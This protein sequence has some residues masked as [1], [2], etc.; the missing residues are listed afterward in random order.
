MKKG[1][2]PNTAESIKQRI[3]QDEDGCWIWQGYKDRDGYGRMRLEGKERFTHRIAYEAWVAALEPNK[4][5]MHTCDKPA[6]CNP[7]HLK[8]GTQGENNRD[9]AAK[10]RKAKGSANGNA[11][12]TEY[13]VSLIRLWFT[14]G[15]SGEELSKIFNISRVQIR[16]ILTLKNW[17]F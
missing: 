6:C 5:I 1:R 11:K 15:V 10:G 3:I 7:E 2:K 17:D 13:Q 8:Q 4:V 9:C 16:K 12:L 14:K